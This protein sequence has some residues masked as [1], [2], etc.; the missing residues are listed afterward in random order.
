MYKWFKRSTLQQINKRHFLVRIME[1]IVH[2][3]LSN[4]GNKMSNSNIN[5]I[6]FYEQHYTK[7]Q[8][9]RDEHKIFIVQLI[10]VILM[11]EVTHLNIPEVI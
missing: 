8:I 11:V 5:T 9:G 7:E 2:T 6:R 1:V 10:M 4:S 3:K